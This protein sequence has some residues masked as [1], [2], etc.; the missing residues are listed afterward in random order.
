MLCV[1]G[2]CLDKTEDGTDMSL[3][4]FQKFL[5]I[6]IVSKNSP[7]SVP[8]PD[9]PLTGDQEI[10]GSIPARLGN[11]LSWR[12]MKYFYG[13]SLQSTDSRRELTVSGE[14]ICTNT[15]VLVNSLED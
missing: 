11:I 5:L 4:H 7:T 14:R 10:A 3:F 15:Q 12:L 13:H 1:N 8:Q 2:H 6:Q 9:I